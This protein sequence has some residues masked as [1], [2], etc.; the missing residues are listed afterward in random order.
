MTIYYVMYTLILLG[1]EVVVR[2]TSDPERRKRRATIFIT[3]VI[4]LVLGLRHPSMGVDLQ[5]GRPYGYLWS[6]DSIAAY[7]VMDLIR[8]KG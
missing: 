7:S 4:T 8:L 6:F 3:M 5:Y 2:G 1:T